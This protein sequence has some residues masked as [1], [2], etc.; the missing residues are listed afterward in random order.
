MILVISDEWE[1]QD[2]ALKDSESE[3]D[4]KS[5]MNFF[6]STNLITDQAFR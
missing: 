4:V 2:Q 3:I 5:R 1:R 6:N